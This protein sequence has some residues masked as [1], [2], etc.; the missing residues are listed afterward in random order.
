MEIIHNVPCSAEAG[1]ISK[2]LLFGH[3]LKTKQYPEV[4]AFCAGVASL[5]E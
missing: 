2:V 4:E 1:S 3:N 5:I